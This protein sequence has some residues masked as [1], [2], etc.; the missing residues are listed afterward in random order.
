MEE[1]N[2]K[3]YLKSFKNER[4]CYLP[5]PGN[6]GD[7]LVA[8]AT[9]QILDD[10]RINYRLYS[11][12]KLN[13]ENKIL[14][15]GGGGSLVH[16]YDQTVGIIEK[17]HQKVKKLVILPHTI[18]YHENLLKSFKSNVDIFCREKVSYDYVKN[19]ASGAN[20]MLTDDLAF[21]LKVD[22][23]LTKDS[24]SLLKT[25]FRELVYLVKNRNSRFLDFPSL[26]ELKYFLRKENELFKL[27]NNNTLN[28]F[29][30]DVEKTDLILPDNNITLASLLTSRK[31]IKRANS[32]WVSN[33]LLRFINHFSKVKTNRLHIAIAAALLNKEVYLYKNSYYKNEAVYRYSM[34]K[35]FPNV[36]FMG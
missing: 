30:K 34:E 9:F 12:E 21:N 14:F 3:E 24:D 7:S 22:E 27:R 35:R 16:Y 13:L 23:I 18:N 20:V 36:Q 5:N 10:L 8:C 4:I 19:I 11:S 26:K 29:R 31:P 28:C 6:A 32:F 15:F 33:Q 1:I 17:M 25:I 2:I